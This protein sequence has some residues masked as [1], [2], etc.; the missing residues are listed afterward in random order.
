MDPKQLPNTKASW[1]LI[2]EIFIHTM[3]R[4]VWICWE[5]EVRAGHH[6]AQPLMTTLG[7]ESTVR[8]SMSL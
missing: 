5:V 6:C 8:A 2:C 7:V 4:R 3:W 1:H